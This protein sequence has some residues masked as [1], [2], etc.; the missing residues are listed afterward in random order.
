MCGSS[1]VASGIWARVTRKL[2]PELA[3][4]RNEL[5]EA[6]RKRERGLKERKK[7]RIAAES[8]N[9]NQFKS[10][11]DNR[12]SQRASQIECRLAS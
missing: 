12:A 7:L 2:L 8:I 11:L 5:E 3:A 6:Q 9:S 10:R 1:V 4:S